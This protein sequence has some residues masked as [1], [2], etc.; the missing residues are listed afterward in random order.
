M[1]VKLTGVDRRIL[2]AIGSENREGINKIAAR[3]KSHPDYVRHRIGT[4]IQRGLV[5]CFVRPG[6]TNLLRVKA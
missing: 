5:D 6:M 4:L 1:N 3:A 2:T